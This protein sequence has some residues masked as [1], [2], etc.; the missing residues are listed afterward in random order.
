MTNPETMVHGT[1]S[2]SSGP[3]DGGPKEAPPILIFKDVGQ[4]AAK[5]AC[6]VQHNLLL[7]LAG[8]S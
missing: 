2:S 4:D 3:R 8:A 6:A 5:N 1:H 7:S